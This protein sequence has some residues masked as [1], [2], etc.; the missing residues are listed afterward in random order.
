MEM[1]QIRYFLAVCEEL[2]FTRAAEKCHVAQPSLTRAIKLL[3]DEL[4]GPLFHRERA[5]THLSELGRVMR[6]YLEETYRQSQQARE[7]AANFVK[8]ENTPLKL[9]IMC[10]IGPDNLI[11]LLSS[12]QESHP[13]VELQIADASATVLQQRLLDGDLEAAIYCLPD[14]TDERLHALPLFREPFVIAINA[15][16]RLARKNA[17]K[18]SD[19][20]GERY[21]NRTNCEV[22]DQARAIF[23]EHGSKLDRVYRSERD[24]WIL[25]MV[26]AGMGFGFL[27]QY[28]VPQRND[29]IVRPLVE[30]EIWREV[31][32]FTVRGRPHSPAVGAL[33]REAMR[34]K[35]MGAEPIGTAR[36]RSEEEPQRARVLGV[37]AT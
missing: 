13:G 5:R 21:L 25:A 34:F 7:V 26:A 16:H 22:I 6:P 19:L 12:I 1:H 24:D 9:G 18:A 3:E 31:S 4:G 28:C 10:T 29:V 14:A 2:N 33:V 17:V 36:E 15:Q 23:R 32:L 20:D 35:W 37:A 11:G 30:P 27:P 8:L